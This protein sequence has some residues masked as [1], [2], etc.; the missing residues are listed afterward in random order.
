MSSSA[1]DAAV[2][3]E[4]QRQKEFLLGQIAFL[5]VAV[6]GSSMFT[7]AIEVAVRVLHYSVWFQ[8][9]LFLPVLVVGGVWTIRVI[10]TNAELTTGIPG[11]VSIM[12]YTCYAVLMTGGVERSPLVSL[13]AIVPLLTRSA[14]S[15][16]ARQRLIM[17]AAGGV[18]GIYACSF[19]H[20]CNVAGTFPI[21]GGW[22]HTGKN[23]R[24]ITVAVILFGLAVEGAALRRFQKFAAVDA[25]GA[26]R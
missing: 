16:E 24:E 21:D 6:V 19:T 17:V 4:A 8:A 10:F 25:S 20:W 3:G 2:V 5:S 15:T 11:P 14:M 13:V 1:S 26:G 12:L 23:G 9:A 18:V 7:P 22:T